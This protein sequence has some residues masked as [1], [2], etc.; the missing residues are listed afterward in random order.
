MATIYNCQS[1]G[2]EVYTDGF[3]RNE[4]GL[5]ER[6]KNWKPLGERGADRLLIAF[7]GDKW[8]V[9]RIRCVEHD[10]DRDETVYRCDKPLGGPYGRLSDVLAVLGA[11]GG[12]CGAPGA[13]NPP[14]LEDFY[15]EAGP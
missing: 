4:S 14:G 9:R 2:D 10:M 6:C 1:C 5:C 13:V 15:E 3:D 8:F 11:S 7:D 12:S